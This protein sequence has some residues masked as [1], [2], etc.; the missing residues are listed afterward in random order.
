MFKNHKNMTLPKKQ[1]ILVT[2]LI[3]L[4]FSLRTS[5]QCLNPAWNSGGSYSTGDIVSHNNKDWEAIPSGQYFRNPS[6]PY[7]HFGW[8]EVS[9][10]CASA[11]APVVASTEA[12][13]VYC[14]TSFGVGT[15][16]SDGGATITARGFVFGLSSNPTLADDAVLLDAGTGVGDEFEGLME[17]LSPETTYYVRT[18]ATNS[19]G[20]TY[21]SET[22]FTT[23]AS[24]DC[25]SDCALA[26]DMTN[27]N[28]LDPTSAEWSSTAFS[29]I[30]ASDTVCVTQ[31]VT[32]AG[33]ITLQGMLKIC[34]GAQITLSGSI[35][36]EREYSGNPNFKGQVVY[37]G[38]DEIFD[39]IGSYTGEWTGTQNDPLQ[40]ISYCAT[41]VD[42]DQSQFFKPTVSTAFWG[43]TCRPTS[44]L[45][46]PL[47][48]ELTGFSVEGHPEGVSLN[49]T[50]SSEINNSHF[51][52]ELSY[53]GVNWYTI[54]FVQGAGNSTEINDYQFIDNHP[55][56][57]VH[58][59]RL[60]QVDY[61][62]AD[63]YSNI[64]Y[65]SFENTSKPSS[66]IA[67]QNENKNIEIQ[68]VFSGAGEAYLIDTRGRTIEQISFLSSDRS[69]LQ[70][71]F[72]TTNL[73][74]G[75]YFVKIKSGNALLGQKVQVVK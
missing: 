23:R 26:C 15:I 14:T 44:T 17:N 12:R 73:S 45:I 54:G 60:K 69:G 36:V 39:G 53:D 67:F 70:F 10:P 28:L 49:W 24:A 7:G 62:G 52:V 38:C 66:F 50:T 55:G 47:P 19:E 34:N 1:S 74:E 37:E 22:N 3:L 2:T 4:F 11:S 41:C 48:V 43:A 21:G 29:T 42:N 75:I 63:S 68:A 5:A 13:G 64:N 51:E 16:T 32:I 33:T 25:V 27:S 65:F 6:G 20:T 46:T 56:S 8:T 9:N 57:G 59:Y 40:M 58:Y 35:E 71:E 18:Y 61:N 31:D 30:S 72:Q